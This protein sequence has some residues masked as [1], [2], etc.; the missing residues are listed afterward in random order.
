[1]IGV[2]LIIRRRILGVDGA[3]TKRTPILRRILTGAEKEKL[4]HYVS[5]LITV[6]LL[7]ILAFLMPILMAVV[8]QQTSFLARHRYSFLIVVLILTSLEQWFAWQ[9]F[10]LKPLG[11]MLAL[12]TYFI[13][14]LIAC[15]P[16]IDP[17]GAFGSQL[18]S[19]LFLGLFLPICWGKQLI[20]ELP[21]MLP[22][23]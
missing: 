9:K 6:V 5:K 15:E 7:T 10:E 1:M 2:V 13:T 17:R 20:E 23:E 21:L 3:E 22:H 8:E 14:N 16:L 4:R 18:V 19:V 11:R 12:A